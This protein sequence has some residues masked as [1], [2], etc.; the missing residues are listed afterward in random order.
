LRV[1]VNLAFAD[2]LF[3]WGPPGGYDSVARCQCKVH[4]VIQG[5]GAI[6]TLALIVFQPADTSVQL[7]VRDTGRVRIAVWISGLGYMCKRLV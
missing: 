1:R 3:K 4:G 6:A 2:V 5:Q 7:R